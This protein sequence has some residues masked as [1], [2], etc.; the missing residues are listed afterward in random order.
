MQGLNI[1]VQ[2]M[3]HHYLLTEKIQAIADAP[4]PS[5]LRH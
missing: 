2:P 5:A 1:P 3:E 4:K